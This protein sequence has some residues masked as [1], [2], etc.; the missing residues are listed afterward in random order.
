MQDIINTGYFLYL[1]GPGAGTAASGGAVASS[2]AQQVYEGRDPALPNDPTAPAL[3]FPTGGGT[4]TQ[5][6]PSSQSWV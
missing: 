6:A 5:F 4:L 3:S 1:G 2:G